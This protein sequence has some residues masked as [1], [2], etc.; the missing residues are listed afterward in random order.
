MSH[1]FTAQMKLDLFMKDFAL[2]LD[3]GRFPTEDI[4]AVAHDFGQGGRRIRFGQEINA[5]FQRQVASNDLDAVTAGVDHLQPG[6]AA[7]EPLGQFAAGHPLGALAG[8]SRHDSR[9]TFAPALP[10]RFSAT[11]GD[12]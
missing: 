12:L 8:A 2:M 1:D 9:A 5:A 10:L 6:F 4:E 3:E 11:A 7:L